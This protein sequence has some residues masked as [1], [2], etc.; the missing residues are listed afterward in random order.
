MTVYPL[1][2]QRLMI[3]RHLAILEVK[4]ADVWRSVGTYKL[5]LID[6]ELSP[7]GDLGRFVA[8]YEAEN[9]SFDLREHLTVYRR[10]K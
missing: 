7:H 9:D 10:G 3:R 8:I 1:G 4:T 6:Y 5:P 2:N